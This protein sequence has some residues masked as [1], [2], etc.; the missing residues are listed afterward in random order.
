M[1]LL[2]LILCLPVSTRY[3]AA[4]SFEIS[5][6]K[7][8]QGDTLSIVINATPG[9][10]VPV[11]LEYRGSA[12][13]SDGKYWIKLYDVSIPQKPNSFYVRASGVANLRVDVKLHRIGWI[14]LNK[15]ASN[16]VVTLSQSNI[17]S[18]TYDI[19]IKGDALPGETSIDLRFTAKITL[20]MDSQ[21]SYSYS[22]DTDGIPR[23]HSSWTWVG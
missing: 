4:S 14:S 20:T 9:E 1:P 17:P 15:D 19:E 11:S 23:G 16:G 22:Y 8:E 5:P 2:L 10:E 3:C 6:S 18:G 7:P 21:G 12:D 13:V